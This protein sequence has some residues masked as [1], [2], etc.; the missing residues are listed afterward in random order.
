LEAGEIF[1][2]F[3]CGRNL[4][5]FHNPATVGDSTDVGKRVYNLTIASPPEGLQFVRILN[6]MAILSIISTPTVASF[7]F[8]IIWLSIYL[9]KT[10]ENEDQVDV[11][12]VTTTAF[13]VGIYL[14]TA[15]RRPIDSLL[16]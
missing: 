1:E 2:V 9:R 3:E 7:M 13:T 6:H 11:Q 16:P 5:H 8:I 10:K 15:G 12:V 4:R 14:V